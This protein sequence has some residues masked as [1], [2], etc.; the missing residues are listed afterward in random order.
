MS[1]SVAQS[2]VVV[3]D[4]SAWQTRYPELAI[5]ADQGLAQLYFN[6]ACLYLDNSP[7]SIVTDASVGGQRSTLLNMLVAHLADLYSGVNGEDP[8]PLVGRL[9]R[10]SEGSVSGSVELKVP[11]SAAWFAQ[12]KYGLSYWAAT[13]AFRTARYVPSR[14]GVTNAFRNS[15][16]GYLGS[17]GYYGSGF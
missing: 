2:G 4:Y 3:F 6:E 12:T 14:Q 11:N 13:M 1:G 7:G 16:R 5:S 9:S 17:G 15:I 10:V 8:S